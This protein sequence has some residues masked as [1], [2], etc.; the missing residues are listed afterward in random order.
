VIGVNSQI[1]TG[2]NGNGNVGI[3]FA[4]PANTVRDV[5]PR[6][7]RGE[8]IRRPYLGVS[9]APGDG[10]AQVQE[11]TA[12][13]PAAAAGLRAGDLIVSVGGQAVREPDDVAAAIQDRRPGQTVAIEIERGGDRRTLDVQLATRPDRAP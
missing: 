10:G 4:V 11:A 6:L 9:T 8:S 12:G 5:I 2:G 1:T 13:G 7:E 3:G